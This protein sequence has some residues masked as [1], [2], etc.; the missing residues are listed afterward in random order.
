[1]DAPLRLR[2]SV[3]G[4][5]LTGAP[6]SASDWPLLRELFADPRS[7]RWLARDPASIDPQAH[8]RR[9]AE[10]FAECWAS[11]GFGPYLLRLGPRPIGYAGLRRS[12]LDSQLE[13]E[14]LWA[15]LP[16]HQGAGRATAAM[17]AVINHYNA[18]ETNA[19][20][21]ASWTLPENAASLRVMQKLGFAY[22]RDAIWAGLR[23]VV[24]RLDDAKASAA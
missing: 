21:V 1:M 10:R 4:S 16:D 9:V 20:R 7:A 2:L 14:A 3:T 17:R 11:D 12:R 13:T 22:E 23:H 18:D 24:Y 6:F 8:A 15:I 5:S 19:P